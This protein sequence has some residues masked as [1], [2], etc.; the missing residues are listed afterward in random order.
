MTVGLVM[1]GHPP[2][3]YRR[4]YLF[5]FFSRRVHALLPVRSLSCYL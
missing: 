3:E 2:G 5:V 4:Q 1:P